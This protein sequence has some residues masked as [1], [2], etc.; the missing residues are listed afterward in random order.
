LRETLRAAADAPSEERR[1]LVWER[2]GRV[3]GVLV[4]GVFAG[5]VGAGRLHLVLVAPAARRAGVGTALLERAMGRLRA[6]GARFLLA[7][8]P[9]DA[10]TCGGY[11]SFLMARDFFEEAR[12]PD[13]VRD[14]VAMTFLRGALR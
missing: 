2:A 3:T 11:R 5:T 9:D 4:Y 13:L 14:G 1:G 7:E 6:E 12:V 8:V 10:A